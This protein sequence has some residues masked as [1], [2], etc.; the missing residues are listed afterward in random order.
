MAFAVPPEDWPDRQNPLLAV[1]YG[2]VREK[3]I[4]AGLQTRSIYLGSVPSADSS[5]DKWPWTVTP[6]DG[7]YGTGT[8]A[9]RVFGS[10]SPASFLEFVRLMLDDDIRS[11]SVPE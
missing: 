2:E 11:L 4:A 7:R 10:A 3:Q 8:K 6:S 1:Q 9:D 5:H